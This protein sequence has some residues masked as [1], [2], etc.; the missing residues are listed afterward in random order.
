[1]GAFATLAEAI[2][3]TVPSGLELPPGPTTGA[4]LLLLFDNITDW[5]F[6]VLLVAA[7]IF[8]VLAAF[9]FITQGGDPGAVTQARTKLLWAAV[10]IVVAVMAK[11]IPI[12]IRNIVG[13]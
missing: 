3:E 10:G 6:V 9:Q 12:V 13:I 5:I 4:E 8:I 2:G 7:T 11:G 1:M